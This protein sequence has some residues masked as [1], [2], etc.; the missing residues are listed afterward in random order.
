MVVHRSFAL[1]LGVEAS[2]YRYYLFP[3][4]ALRL[5]LVD[6]PHRQGRSIHSRPVPVPGNTP[7]S[8]TSPSHHKS[9]PHRSYTP[10]SFSA[11]YSPVPPLSGSKHFPSIVCAEASNSNVKGLHSLSRPLLW[12]DT[13][14]ELV[15]A[16][17]KMGS[18]LERPSLTSAKKQGLKAL[19]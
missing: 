3:R 17:W 7:G 13:T 1:I 19:I 11:T 9:A 4:K 2:V 18:E 5:L 16:T 14:W 8:S 12:K 6:S 15:S 10:G